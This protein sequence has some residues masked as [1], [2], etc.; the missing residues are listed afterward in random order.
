[1]SLSSENLDHQPDCRVLVVDDDSGFVTLCQRYLRSSGSISFRIEVAGNAMS[2]LEIYSH[3]A[4]DCLIVDYRL[5]DMTGTD[6][7]NRLHA[8][9]DEYTIAPAIV[10][11]A[12]G[13][14]SVAIKAV[15]ANASDYMSKSDITR[16]SLTRAVD[17][18]QSKGLLRRTVYERNEKLRKAH[19]QLKKKSEETNRFYHTLSHEVQTPLTAIH[20]FSGLLRDEIVGPLNEEQHQ[21]IRYSM[22]SCDQITRHFNELL[23]MTRFDTDR[24]VLNKTAQSPSDL[25]NRCI[26]GAQGKAK[27]KAINLSHDTGKELPDIYIDAHRIAQVISNLINNAI[28]FTHHGGEVHVQTHHCVVD[29]TVIIKISDTGPGIEAIH[30]SKIFDRLYQVHACETHND[31]SGGLGLGL[32][33]ANEIVER[34]S[35]SINVTSEIGKGSCF[36]IKLPL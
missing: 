27:Q 22:E 24:F 31:E 32:S 10:M 4:F 35:G 20:E 23:E 29:H 1:M 8:E 18:A 11:T 19:S 2:A 5:P 25:V 14:E 15:R 6:L 30:L 28:K 13:D 36:M 3:A 34:H 21:L 9:Y 16:A 33:I 17:N 7:L 26:K 12:F